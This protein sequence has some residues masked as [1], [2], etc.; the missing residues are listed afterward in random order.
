M[1]AKKFNG[2]IISADSRT[3]YRGLNIGTAKVSGK[4]STCLFHGREKGRYFVY[5]KIPHH[6]IDFLTP[7]KTF[8]A[9]D[10]AKHAKKIIRQIQ[11]RNHLPILCG[12][13]GFWIDAL[14]DPALL[15]AVPPNPRLR[16][17]L[18][19][20]TVAQLFSQLKKL[21]P[22]RAHA[23][24]KKNKRRLIRAIEIVSYRG[25]LSFKR[26]SPSAPRFQVLWIGLDLPNAELKEK[27]RKRFLVWIKQGLVLETK[28]LAKQVKSK[29]LREIGLAYPIVAEYLLGKISK[30][31]MIERSVNAIYHYAKRQKTWFKKTPSIHWVTKSGQAKRLTSNFL[32]A[33]TSV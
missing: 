26:G 14:F 4:W 21:A 9:A 29:R 6:L 11:K 24:D 13:T 17:Q 20:N 28:K 33:E 8:S 16:G 3:I 27:I 5:K 15:P 19:K 22:N 10:F 31:Q 1:L 25:R 12:G 7:D 30:D 18:E 23:I 32:K 2:E